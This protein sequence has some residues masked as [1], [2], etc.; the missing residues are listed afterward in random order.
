MK[1]INCFLSIFV[2]FIMNQTFTQN[3]TVLKGYDKKDYFNKAQ[4]GAIS[5]IKEPTCKLPAK[6]LV[7]NM[8]NKGTIEQK[9]FSWQYFG[10]SLIS[11]ALYNIHSYSG[12][13][14]DS[15][16]CVGYVLDM[17]NV[18]NF[19]ANLFSQ[20]VP[21]GDPA[22]KTLRTIIKNKV[23]HEGVYQWLK[24]GL[25]LAWKS[26]EKRFYDFYKG[27]I[28]YIKTFDYLSEKKYYERL[29]NEGVN[30]NGDSA[31]Q[32]FTSHEPSGKYDSRRKMKAW[33]FRR[34]YFD[35]WDF[36]YVLSW[37]KRIEKEV[38]V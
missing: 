29:K 34:I 2:F 25:A 1:K 19:L 32:K 9:I 12:D 7:F 28:S 13:G 26:L 37:I 33:V 20:F 23:Y 21:Q 38:M 31:M 6:S 35:N 5:A 11:N 17:T 15:N 3:T 8:E 27:S 30:K 10:Q 22:D 36:V 18:N 14:V 4:L 16:V 24:P